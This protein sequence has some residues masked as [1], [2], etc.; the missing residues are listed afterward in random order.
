MDKV[1]LKFVADVLYI[2]ECICY[3]EFH[4]IM[5]A[6]NHNDLES[7]VE[8]MLREDFNHLVGQKKKKSEVVNN[9]Y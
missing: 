9:E 8:R 5:N 7:I 1:I 2:K 3:D 6:T 4:A